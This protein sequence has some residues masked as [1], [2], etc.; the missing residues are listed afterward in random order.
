[1][2]DDICWRAIVPLDFVGVCDRAS[3]YTG[4]SLGVWIGDLGDRCFVDRA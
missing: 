4:V 1:M 2:T 3:G